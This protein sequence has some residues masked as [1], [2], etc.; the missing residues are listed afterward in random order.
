MGESVSSVVVAV[1][2]V[3][4]GRVKFGTISGNVVYDIV[5]VGLSHFP[6]KGLRWERSSLFYILYRKLL[7]GYWTLHHC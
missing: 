2:T 4:S 6:C 3:E 7:C 1:F 5:G